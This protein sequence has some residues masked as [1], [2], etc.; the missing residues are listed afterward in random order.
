[1]GGSS[2]LLTVLRS[3]KI[4]DSQEIDCKIWSWYL[5]SVFA[6]TLVQISTCLQLLSCN[7][8][9]IR[10]ESFPKLMIERQFGLVLAVYEKEV[11]E[12]IPCVLVLRT[13]FIR[14]LKFGQLSSLLAVH[15]N[16]CSY[17][18]TYHG[19]RYTRS[20]L[21]LVEPMTPYIIGKILT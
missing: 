7:I 14:C 13:S 20:L 2:K 5:I 6:L 3:R 8:Y 1:M 19:K 16:G 10:P 18:L 15:R 21:Q 11:S 12:N 4:K 9:V 17:H